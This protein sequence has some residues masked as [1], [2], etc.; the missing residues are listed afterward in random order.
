MKKYY[1]L[2]FLLM[3]VVCFSQINT[4]NITI[5]RDT[6]G[7]PHIFAP[8]DAEV[9]YGLAWA[10]CEDDF[11]HIQLILI[12]VKGQMGRI[13]GKDGAAT[14]YFVEFT[15]AR[16]MVDR[17]Y[18]R[19]VTYNFKNNL[20][21]YSDGVNAYAA[22][23]SKEVLLKNIFPITPQDI[24][25]GYQLILTSMVG[26]PYALQHIIKGTPD[27][28]IFSANAGSNAFALSSAMT[29]DSAAYLVI[30]PHVPLEGQAS[31]YEAHVCSEQGWN[32]YGA[33]IPGM[34][35]PAMGCNERLGWAITFNWPDYVDIYDMELNPKNKNQYKF[36]GDW[37]DFEVRKIP[38]KVKTK[39]GIIT[40]KKEALWC[41]YGPAYRTKKGVYALRYNTLFNV[42]AA[43]QWFNLG[44]SQDFSSFHAVMQMQGIPLF[45]FMY[46]DETDCIHYLFNAYIPKRNPDYNWQKVVP[47]NTS[48]TYWNQFYT[49]SE[50]PQKHRPTCGYLYN[51][52]NTPF[53]CTAP[54]ENLK[55]EHYNK[56]SAYNW[57]RVNN[58]DLRFSELIAGKA[59]LS[60]EEL[61]KIKYDCTYPKGGGIYKTYKP[62]YDLKET[63]Y[64]D[65]A[66]AI[67]HLKKWDFTGDTNNT[68][69][70]LALLTFNYLFKK[71]DAG[72]NELETGIT[73]D[74][75]LLIDAIRY[76]KKELLTHY[77]RIDVPFGKV[78]LLIRE[79][80]KYA[81]A[82]LPECLRT[83]A[84]EQTNDGHQKAVNG[85]S[86][87]MF[88][89]FSKK[90]NSYET[91]VPYGASRRTKSSHLHDQMELYTTEKTKPVTL[92]KQQ[93]L[94]NATRVYHPK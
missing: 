4:D 57:N 84:S 32:M 66:D 48:K 1:L 49:I 16:S 87:I 22:A 58:R 35:S 76:A 36:D 38:L 78:Q 89:K 90:G 33:L 25:T 19:D 45:N 56:Q 13:T 31:W 71:K 2:F 61:K 92:N 51:T 63:D 81:V 41:I 37:Y 43:E 67:T 30:N 54:E 17:Y 5:A 23:H 20:Q 18:E 69:T 53:R 68:H 47:G 73:Y 46:A 83:I 70:A 55:E 8:T 93:V 60:F 21:A 82:G 34:I 24:I 29:H 75:P 62:I 74:T 44:K 14:D 52:N 15:K 64:P 42:K 6:F 50:L 65:I 59:T 28:Y 7:V 91:I 10:H 9:A 12:T 88:A 77:K 80:K 72:Y 40:V 94:Q 85:D 11:E 39:L 26:V 27:D 86:F 3:S 79:N